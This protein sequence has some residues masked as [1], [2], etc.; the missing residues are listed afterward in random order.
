MR[1]ASTTLLRARS[2]GPA[3]LAGACAVLLLGGCGDDSPTG[4]RGRTI[5]VQVGDFF[6]QPA[7]V[8]ARPGDTVRWTQTGMIPHT[9]TSGDPGAPDAGSLFDLD[10]ETTADV[11]E[12]EVPATAPDTIPY[13]CRPHPF[14]TGSIVVSR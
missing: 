8:E 11:E 3:A 13:F 6:F 5:D 14:M 10:L 1:R 9:A 12:F 2:L 7:V 4:P